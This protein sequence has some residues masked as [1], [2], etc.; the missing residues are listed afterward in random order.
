MLTLFKVNV[1]NYFIIFTLFTNFTSF[2]PLIPCLIIFA[3]TFYASLHFLQHTVYCIS[4]YP[5]PVYS[6]WNILYSIWWLSTPT[7]TTFYPHLFQQWH[8]TTKKVR[9]IT[10]HG[11]LNANTFFVK[12][13]KVVYVIMH[14]IIRKSSY[15]VAIPPS[16]DNWKSSNIYSKVFLAPIMCWAVLFTSYIANL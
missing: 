1:Y 15:N 12:K 7:A 9:K 2:I 14:T 4:Q 10:W 16:A 3:S 8:P 6:L 13:E 11:T 5:S